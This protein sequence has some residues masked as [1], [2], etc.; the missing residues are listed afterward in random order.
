MR[1]LIK[2][3]FWLVLSLLMVFCC[4]VNAIGQNWFVFAVCVIA[5]ALD[6]NNAFI[7]FILWRCD[8]ARRSH[9]T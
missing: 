8:R 3:I 9:D 4:I 6:I 5:F 2:A 7:A 1:H